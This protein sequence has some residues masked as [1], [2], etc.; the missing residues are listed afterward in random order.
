MAALVLYMSALHWSLAEGGTRL[1]SI[2][3]RVPFYALKAG[4]ELWPGGAPLFT[5]ER[6]QSLPAFLVL[7]TDAG[8]LGIELA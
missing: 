4:R 3:K 5:V 7:D 6:P 1:R 8:P 2:P